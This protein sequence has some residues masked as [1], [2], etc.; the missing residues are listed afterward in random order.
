MNPPWS[1]SKGANGATDKTSCAPPSW[2]SWFAA[3]DPGQT[4]GLLRARVRVLCAAQTFAVVRV[5]TVLLLLAL[6]SAGRRKWWPYLSGGSEFAAVG[7]ASRRQPVSASVF[8]LANHQKSLPPRSS[9]PKHRLR[10]IEHVSIS[11]RTQHS[12]PRLRFRYASTCPQSWP[13]A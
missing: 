9:P 5:P 11:S 4:A 2:V 7:E 8:F 12:Q 1:C 10:S 6:P 13:K 3:V